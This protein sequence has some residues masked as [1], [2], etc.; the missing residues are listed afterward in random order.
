MDI[1][2]FIRFC[3]WLAIIIFCIGLNIISKKFNISIIRLIKNNLVSDLAIISFLISMF[4]VENSGN[5][6]ILGSVDYVFGLPAT[7]IGY[8]LLFWGI[9]SFKYKQ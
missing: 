7:I 3:N 1:F 8:I 6:D 5:G 2:P 9:L 4:F